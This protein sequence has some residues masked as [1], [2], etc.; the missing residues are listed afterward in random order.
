MKKLIILIF[1]T[2]LFTKP[3]A[4]QPKIG[5]DLENKFRNHKLINPNDSLNKFITKLRH[6]SIT[7]TRSRFSHVLPN[8]DKVYLLPDDMPCIVPD[9]SRYNYNMPVY[10]GKIIGAIPNASPPLQIIPKEETK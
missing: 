5:I 9:M 8:G 4:Q 1:V 7:L 2:G 10:K 6:P 3:F